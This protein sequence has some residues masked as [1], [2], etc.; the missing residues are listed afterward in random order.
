LLFSTKHL[1]EYDS[2]QGSVR[3]WEGRFVESQDAA[4]NWSVELLNKS[5]L[6]KALI[7][8]TSWATSQSQMTDSGKA[9][10][11]VPSRK[12]VRQVQTISLLDDE[13][14]P[15]TEKDRKVT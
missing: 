2:E 3:N 4:Q 5:E 6:K 7:D 14:D 10:E 1:N 11:E 12:P 9:K 15:S 13:R 8:C